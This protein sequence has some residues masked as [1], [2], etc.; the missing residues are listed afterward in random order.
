MHQRVPQTTA[1]RKIRS[2]VVVPAGATALLYDKLAE[3]IGASNLA[4]ALDV[5]P[6]AVKLSLLRT[7]EQVIALTAVD[8]LCLQDLMVKARQIVREY[9]LEAE[10]E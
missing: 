7:L 1:Y 4:T 10:I 5:R 6:G 3:C 2:K 9:G 8:D